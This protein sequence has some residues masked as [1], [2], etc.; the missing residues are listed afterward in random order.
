MPGMRLLSIQQPW[1]ELILRGL[2][3]VENR[4]WRTNHQGPLLIHASRTVDK[5][6]VERHGLPDDIRRGA[7]VGVVN[8]RR[9]TKQRTSPCHKV[10]QWGWYLD[11]PRRFRTP[12]P[13]SAGV[14]LR[15]V[16]DR[17]VV[18]AARS[19]VADRPAA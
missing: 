15:Q 6:E 9:C 14:G 7:I 18:R 16:P 4:K 12:V 5:A 17:L 11:Q 19:A 13:F 10:G 2:K 8:V 1:A 3:D